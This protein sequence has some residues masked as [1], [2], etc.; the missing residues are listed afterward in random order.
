MDKNGKRRTQEERE[1][2]EYEFEQA[3]KMAQ[4]GNTGMGI[5]SFFRFKN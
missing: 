3:L 5:D 1:T 4:T 2:V